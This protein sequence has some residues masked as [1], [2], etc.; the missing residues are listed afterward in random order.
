MHKF[1]FPKSSRLKNKK[2]F[3]FVYQR[4]KAYVVPCGALYVFP[5]QDLKI[6]LAVGK[7]LGCAVVRNHVKR[8]MREAF[9]HHRNKFS[10]KFHLIWVARYKLVRAD[11]ADFER[12]LLVL[13]GR[14]GILVKSADN[15]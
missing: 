9:R 6:G 2:R 15:V 1:G 11:L 8:M 14:A 4:G 13:A 7:K 12:T 3:Q 5:A 10:P